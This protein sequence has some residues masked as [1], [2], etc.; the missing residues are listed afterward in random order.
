MRITY[1]SAQVPPLPSPHPNKY[2]PWLQVVDKFLKDR[3]RE[4]QAAK[5]AEEAEADAI[6]AAQKE[7]DDLAARGGVPL[8]EGPVKVVF[9]AVPKKRDLESALADGGGED[10]GDDESNGEAGE[11]KKKKKK[12]K[13][14]NAK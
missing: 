3:E 9:K 11:R 6:A 10:R 14:D 7:A 4:K 13:L 2:S 5:E 12:K 8:E 1:P